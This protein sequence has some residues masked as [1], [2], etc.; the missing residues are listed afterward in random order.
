M[1]EPFS[2]IGVANQLN[3][4]IKQTILKC[5]WMRPYS[6]IGV[7]SQ[8]NDTIKQP[9]LQ[10][11]KGEEGTTTVI[12]VIVFSITLVVLAF[13]QK[14]CFSTC[15]LRFS[16]IGESRIISKANK[17]LRAY[18]GPYKEGHWGVVHKQVCH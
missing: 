18:T 10:C 1:D 6:N 7:P 12:L 13:Y 11:T 3:D 17:S 16:W 5:T 2:N 4:T 9:N 8:L 15:V 14:K